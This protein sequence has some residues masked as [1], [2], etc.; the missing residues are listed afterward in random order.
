MGFMMILNELKK[1]AII[2]NIPIVKDN[3]LEKITDIIKENN[4]K[5]ILEI[6]TAIGYSAIN[7]ALLDKDIKVFSIEKDENRFFE[8][9]EN[10]KKFKLDDQI[11]VINADANDFLEQNEFVNEYKNFIKK[12]KFDVLFIDAAKGQYLNFLNKSIKYFK[13][14]S[15]IIADNILFK[16]YV[17]GEYKEKKHRTIVNNLREF[18]SVLED[19]EYFDTKIFEVDDGL[20][21][22]R[23]K[24][25]II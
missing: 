19:E 6:G 25:S 13:V 15:F 1:E 11:K 23:I 9:K 4:L 20:L 14:D 7:F 22:S 18:I 12:D 17:L 2:N 10:I 5:N 8:A 3:T 16:G 24:K 21:I